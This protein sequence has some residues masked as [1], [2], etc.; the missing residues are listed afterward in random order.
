MKDLKK[1][2]GT[3]AVV[4]LVTVSVFAQKP[5]AEEKADRFVERLTEKLELTDE[6]QEKIKAIAT[7]FM[8]ERENVFSETEGD[9]EARKAQMKELHQ[10]SADQIL[11]ILTDEQK[12]V[13]Q[14]HIDERK[15]GHCHGMHHGKRKGHFKQMRAFMAQERAAFDEKLT[16]EEKAIIDEVREEVIAIHER[17]NQARFEYGFYNIKVLADEQPEKFEQLMTIAKSHETE[18]KAIRDKAKEHMMKNHCKKGEMKDC[19]KVKG[20]EGN[21]HCKKGHGPHGHGHGHGHMHGGKRHEMKAVFF[22]LLDPNDS[23]TQTNANTKLVV[24]PLPITANTSVQFTIETAGLTTVT[25][26]DANGNIV[27]TLLNEVMEAGSHEV[28]LNGNILSDN[29]V[30]IVK[31]VNGNTQLTQKI[32][33]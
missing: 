7:E 32:V 28:S 25:V 15:G 14:K 3:I 1:I 30:Y 24:S 33:K 26:S 9:H 29:S 2:I 4:L 10:K 21:G 8:V 12:V 20:P 6:Q 18:L 22:L 27:A 17:E 16:D 23:V 13:F 11:P 31:L 5:T 19:P